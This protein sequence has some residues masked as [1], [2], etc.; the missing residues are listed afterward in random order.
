MHFLGSEP[1][2]DRSI[3][4][5]LNRGATGM[6]ILVWPA[7]LLLYRGRLGRLALALPVPLLLLLI[8]ALE[9]AAAILGLAAAI[10][11]ALIALLSRQ[12]AAALLIAAPLA[13]AV[14]MPLLSEW[15]YG[16]QL[17]DRGLLAYSGE[18]RLFLWSFL[19]DNIAEKPLAG[20]GF[21]SARLLPFEDAPLFRGAERLTPTHP[22]NAVMQVWV[23]L[24]AV[25]IVLALALLLTLVRRLEHM[26]PAERICA[27]ALLLASFVICCIAYGLWQSQWIATLFAA[28][29]L[30]ILSREGDEPTPRGEKSGGPE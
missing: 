2:P 29:L 14:A 5:E 8:G 9:S 6:A 25:G 24:G 12:L 23:E 4:S 27:Q 13:A 7:T 17:F 21:D 11:L 30:V 19:A 3:L 16:L 28:A 18:H 10:L 22:H 20:W 15:L 1:D 26:P